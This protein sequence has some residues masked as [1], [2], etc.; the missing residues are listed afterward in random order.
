MADV[1]EQS[2]SIPMPAGTAGG[3]F[4]RPA[5]ADKTKTYPGILH[6]TDI[7]GIREATRAMAKRLAGEGFCV[8]L[9]N[10]FYRDCEPPVVDPALKPGTP[11]AMARIHELFA[12]LTPEDMTADAP[13]YL[14]FLEKQEG[15]HAGAMGVAGYCYTGA[16]ALRTAAACPEKI[17]AAASFHGGRLYTDEQDSPHR[18]L[19][20]VQH[21][22]T[23]LY[24]G[25][26]VKDGSMPEDA[27]RNFEQAL[28][29]WGGIYESETYDDALHGWTV[30]G[31]DVYNEAQAER[32][33]AKM[34]Q[35]FRETLA[36]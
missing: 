25:H 17:A 28:A 13:A 35:L 21:V 20:Q 27:I 15:V 31:R 9:P 3:Y 4:Y 33:Y 34:T 19:P 12:A 7:F 16:M 10:C 29:D 24:F 22:G 14:S 1:T 30:P 18:V 26:A 2:L 5:D 32:A 6:L 36:V 11:E 23:R 8:L